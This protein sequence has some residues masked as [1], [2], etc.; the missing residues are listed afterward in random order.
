V[1]NLS[2]KIRACLGSS[3]FCSVFASSRERAHARGA[4]CSSRAVPGGGAGAHAPAAST[5]RWW[6]VA[7]KLARPD[8]QATIPTD[9]SRPRGA[10][11]ANS[12]LY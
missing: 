9:G 2:L 7:G 11:G 1:S 8:Q 12:R 10:A 3:L 6:A 5:Q 4:L